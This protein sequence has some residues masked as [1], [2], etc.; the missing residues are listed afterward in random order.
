MHRRWLESG[1][2]QLYHPC[3]SGFEHSLQQ[4]RGNVSDRIYSTSDLILPFQVETQIYEKY[5][6]IF[7]DY[8]SLQMVYVDLRACTTSYATKNDE[9]VFLEV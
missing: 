8:N 2:M 3:I 9:D 1:D 6:L 7:K 4:M 5:N